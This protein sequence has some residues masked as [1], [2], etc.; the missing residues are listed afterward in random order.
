MVGLSRCS[1]VPI[2]EEYKGA[3]MSYVCMSQ[4]RVMSVQGC[5]H[6]N[7]LFKP[8]GSISG[9]TNTFKFIMPDVDAKTVYVALIHGVLLLIPSL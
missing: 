4:C 9:C 5:K 1:S 8:M 6:L 7:V 3:G 2:V